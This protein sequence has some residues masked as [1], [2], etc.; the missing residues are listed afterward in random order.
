RGRDRRRVGAHAFAHALARDRSRGGRSA[1]RM[2]CR[3]R[4][5]GRDR[6]SRGRNPR[7]AMSVPAWIALLAPAIVAFCAIAL[8][9]PAGAGRWLVDRPN[10]RSLHAA[11]TPR[12]GGIGVAVGVA[13]AAPLFWTWPLNIVFSLAAILFAVSLADDAR[14]LPM[15]ARLAAHFAAA[16]VLAALLVSNASDEP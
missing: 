16:G 6:R 2:A 3:D 9:R 5:P 13:S 8:L 10:E 1:A 12:L 7:R 11:P 15:Q 4:R 14:S